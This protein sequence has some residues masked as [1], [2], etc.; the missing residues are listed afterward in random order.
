MG[1]RVSSLC[2]RPILTMAGMIGV[3]DSAVHPTCLERKVPMRDADRVLLN[4][5][6]NFMKRRLAVFSLCVTLGFALMPTPA[7]AQKVGYTQQ[8]AATATVADAYI[9][10]YIAMDWNRIEPLLA[11]NA[12]FHDPTAEVLFGSK[13][14][15]GK[16]AIMT[17]FRQGYATV[18]KMTLHRTR[19]IHAGNYGIVEGELEWAVKFPGDRL[20]QSRGPF[21]IIVRVEGG[22]V[23]EHRD[24]VDYAQFIKDERA[25]RQSGS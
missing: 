16:P 4:Q 5:R 1:V 23:V 17:A 24:Y 13:Q 18:T 22:K 19:A 21:I 3:T 6:E 25:S 9:D 10:A 12:T 7:F 8:S 20:V 2:I 14:K 15:E 11:D